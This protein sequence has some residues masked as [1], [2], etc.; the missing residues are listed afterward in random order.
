MRNDGA[1][2][3]EDPP[4]E[5]DVGFLFDSFRIVVGQIDGN[6]ALDVV[7]AEGYNTVWYP[8]VNFNG[9]QPGNPGGMQ[10]TGGDSWVFLTEFGFD[11]DGFAD[12][13]V[14]SQWDARI[15]FARGQGNGSFTLQGM[16]EVCNLGTCDVLELHA[17][18][19]NGD[20]DPDIIASF[21]TGFS[22]VLA[23]GDGTYGDFALNASPGADH[24]S[25]GDID[26]DGDNDLV[27]A[28]RDDGDLRLFLGDGAG[29]FADPMV[30]AVPGDSTRTTAMV[31]MNG[32][33]ALE[34]VTAYDYNG[35]G[36]VAVFE[37]SP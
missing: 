31:D 28:S 16:A 30:F 32:D 15:A 37:A 34:L 20:D 5:I 12:L 22:V 14:A 21:D 9:W 2:G 35:G 27:V 26:N 8:G 3:W 25:S 23:N 4:S 19:L 1:G 13:L 24:I 36:W 33:G 17:V 29:G 10:F 7:F 6:A 11:G 18:D